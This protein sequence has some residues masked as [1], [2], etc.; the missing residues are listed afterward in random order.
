MY[1]E[2]PKWTALNW[3]EVQTLCERINARI[4]NA[5]V[6]KIF[7][8]LRPYSALGYHRNEW[9]FQLSTLENS[10]SFILNLNSQ[11]PYFLL[12]SHKEKNAGHAP[13][14]VFDL[15]LKKNLEGQIIER[16][17]AIPNDRS[18]LF[19]F[20]PHV[21]KQL[22]LYV[23]FYSNNTNG[24]L[25]EKNLKSVKTNSSCAS[26]SSQTFHS[27]HTPDSHQSPDS[28]QLPHSLLSSHSLTCLIDL[29]NKLSQKSFSLP[30]QDFNKAISPRSLKPLKKYTLRPSIEEDYKK[31]NKKSLFHEEI[32]FYFLKSNFTERLEKIKKHCTEQLKFSKKNLDKQQ[33]TFTRAQEEP[34]WSHFGDLMKY[35]FHNL[36]SI[37]DLTPQQT[38]G[39]TSSKKTSRT[40]EPFREI[41]DYTTDK[42]I[43]IPA[44]PKLTP[45]KQIEKFYQLQK[46]KENRLTDSKERVEF[47][48][49]QEKNILNVLKNLDSLFKEIF[50]IHDPS[51]EKITLINNSISELESQF[52]LE[53]FKALKKSTGSINKTQ[54]LLKQKKWTGKI[55]YSSNQQIILV[56]R[57]KKEN[58]A[59][60]FRVANGND[61]WLHV[62]GRPSAHGVIF[63]ENKKSASLE[64]LLDAAHLVIFYSGG[65]K[66]GKTEVDYTFRKNVKKIP[67]SD[68]VR[69]TQNK[70]I[71]VD[72]D[73]ERIKKLFETQTDFN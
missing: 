36:P 59:L 17:E 22:G 26:Q 62:R 14:S 46:R 56:G 7:I 52:H 13:H 34:H 43:I 30:T 21:D 20:K 57:N 27:S 61:I 5:F 70:T 11:N 64:T 49:R 38:Q 39:A 55:F 44:N 16:L 25:F 58:H 41:L 29:K 68:L 60:T 69:Y 37:Q 73:P 2:K 24:I 12:K 8:P 50:T 6:D 67:K 9:A 54:K 3:K 32:E 63:I 51:S 40:I 15:G 45:Q 72:Y 4:Q 31:N 66:W 53:N 48:K 47:L 23:T 65:E 35:H 1:Q 19:W 18:L 33:K 71:H 42:N 10:L 28:R